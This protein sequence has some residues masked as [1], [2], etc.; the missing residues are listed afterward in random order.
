MEMSLG[1]IADRYSI[2]KLKSE[3]TDVDCKEEFDTLKNELNGDEIYTYVDQLYKVN[4]RIWDLESD[5]RK[6]KEGELG[7]EEVGRRAIMIR[8]FN[9]ERINSLVF[10]ALRSS[11]GA[12]G[13]IRS[14]THKAGELG[15][16]STAERARSSAGTLKPESNR[17]LVRVEYLTTD[18]GYILATLIA[19][20]PSPL[21]IAKSC[22]RS[23]LK[24]GK[25]TTKLRKNDVK[26]SR[27]NL[28]FV[29]LLTNS[30]LLMFL[31][32]K[33][34]IDPFITIPQISIGILIGLINDCA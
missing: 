12:L 16:N 11:T 30:S 33:P 4:G 22:N 27:F 28:V 6:G 32:A 20:S 1:E 17:A 7:L 10:A 31:L 8:D 14:S 19:K 23:E 25:S 5:I 15:L 26:E 3:R 9:K 18:S 2:I 29:F 21:F 13:L 24:Y 34:I